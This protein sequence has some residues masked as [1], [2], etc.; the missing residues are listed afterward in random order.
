MRYGQLCLDVL[1]LPAN[2]VSSTWRFSRLARN[3]RRKPQAAVLAKEK[4]IAGAGVTRDC[5][6]EAGRSPRVREKPITKL[7]D[8]YSSLSRFPEARKRPIK[9]RLELEEDAFGPA[10]IHR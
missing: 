7:A 1:Q 3:G 10:R 9:K 6:M 4:G 2:L 8:F 5:A